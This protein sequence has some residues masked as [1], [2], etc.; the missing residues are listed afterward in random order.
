MKSRCPKLKVYKNEAS[1]I[2]VLIFLSFSVR[3]RVVFDKIT[4]ILLELRNCV[5]INLEFYHT[6]DSNFLAV[7]LVS[8]DVTSK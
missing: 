2:R 3:I 8:P 5:L 6:F 4:K 7:I 1:E